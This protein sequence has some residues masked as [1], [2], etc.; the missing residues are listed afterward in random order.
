[1]KYKERAMKLVKNQIYY[2]KDGD[3]I[4]S[5]AK[6]YNVNPTVILIKNK[7]TPNMICKG[8]ILYI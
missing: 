3:T 4:E 7:I 6:E 5:I 2:V 1:M 8:M